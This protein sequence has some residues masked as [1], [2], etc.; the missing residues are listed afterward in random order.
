MIDEIQVIRSEGIPLYYY[1]KEEV[2]DDSINFLQAGF[3]T[4]M[5]NFA[6]DLQNGEMKLVVMEK[7]EYLLKQM[8][9]FLLI[10]GLDIK[11][12]NSIDISS[13]EDQIIKV[14]KYLD[15]KLG[16]YNLRGLD[17]QSDE[18]GEPF[19]EFD[20]FLHSEKLIDKQEFSFPSFSGKVRNR[21]FQSIGYVAG[22]CNIGRAE[23]MRRLAFGMVWFMISMILL[24]ASISFDIATAYRII[25]VIPN[26][27]G[28]SGLYQYFYRFCTTN[29]LKQQYNMN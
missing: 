15:E 16:E 10:F 29:A 26:F 28:F 11:E 13:Y 22:E 9:D 18:Y 19:L 7:K 21:M 24:I 14:A 1:N 2:L 5:G 4:A 12:E 25:L 17:H 6:G 27:M 23:R 3:F 20:I 8:T